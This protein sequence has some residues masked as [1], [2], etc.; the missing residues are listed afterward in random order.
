MIKKINSKNKLIL[1][2]VVKVGGTEGDGD[3]LLCLVLV[4]LNS[5]ILFKY[6]LKV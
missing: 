1:N 5:L 6:L 3:P 4:Y 2:T